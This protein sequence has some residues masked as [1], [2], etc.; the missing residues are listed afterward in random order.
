MKYCLIVN[1]ASGYRKGKHILSSVLPLFTAHDIKIEPFITEYKNHPYIIARDNELSGY[2]GVLVIGGDGTMHEVVNGMMDRKDG[3]KLPLGIIPGGTGNSLVHD[4]GALDPLDAAKL[5]IA[6][7]ILK[8]DLARL[9]M[10]EGH[11]Y[12]FNIV[13]WGLPESVNTRAEKWRNLGG[14]RYNL[15][16]LVEIVRSPVWK[17]K[18]ILDDDILEGNY[19]FFLACNTRYSGNGMQVAPRA[20]LD[21]GEF[22][23]LLLKKEPRWKLFRLFTRIFSGRHID[24]PIITYRKAKSFEIHPANDGILNVDGQLTGH[25]PVKAHVLREAI[26]LFV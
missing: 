15:A 4:L 5:I 10:P 21:D 26:E 9:T 22:D 16:S 25:T 14:Q 23:V 19:S 6:R 13:G 8:I 17:V 20:L 7:N 12:S 24:D 11:L 1:P 18:I 3:L 2:Q